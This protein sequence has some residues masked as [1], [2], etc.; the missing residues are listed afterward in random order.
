MPNTFEIRAFNHKDNCF[1]VQ[2]YGNIKRAK[3]VFAAK[4]DMM[5][6]SHSALIAANLPATALAKSVQLVAY[7]DAKT[8]LE[9]IESFEI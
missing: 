2:T 3:E 6:K 9:E 4:I 5:K 1:K 8:W 7:N